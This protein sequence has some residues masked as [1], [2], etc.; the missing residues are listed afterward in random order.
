MSEPSGEPRRFYGKYRGTV[1]NDLDPMQLGRVQVSVPAVLGEGTLSWAMPCTPY[2]G[3]QVGLFLVPPRGARVWVE[4][5][6]GDPDQPILAGCF[7]GLGEVPASPAVPQLKVLRTEAVTVEVSDVP[8][9][10]GV[11]ISVDPPAVAV[12]IAV[13]A[14]ASG[15]EISVGASKIALTA[16]SVSIN[17]GALEVT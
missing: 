14:T 15:V 13:E 10:G 4:F 17:D 7:W 9:A 6:A 2:A 12:P 5:E 16:A 3:D 11:R 8:G 1:E